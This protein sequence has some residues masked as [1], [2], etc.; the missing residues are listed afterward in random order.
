MPH[1]ETAPAARTGLAGARRT[2]VRS[3]TAGSERGQLLR[4]PGGPAFRTFGPLP[5]GGTDQDLAVAV[6]FFAMKF[7]NRHKRSINQ[8]TPDFNIIDG[9]SGE[10]TAGKNSKLQAP[11][12]REYPNSNRKALTESLET[13]KRKPEL[14]D[15]SSR[16][17][18]WPLLFF[19]LF[20]L[21]C[22]SRIGNSK[23]EPPKPEGTAK[24]ETRSPGRKTLT[25]RLETE[26]WKPE[27]TD[28]GS[29]RG[30]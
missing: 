22:A 12:S 5:I 16:R 18:G 24:S 10:R 30:G 15:A 11:G 3:A 26:K 9:P 13:E 23:L 28:V 20:V 25:E 17:G 1:A 6:A 21:T 29:R 14:T 27:L 19:C 2:F 7:V 4:Q 8:L